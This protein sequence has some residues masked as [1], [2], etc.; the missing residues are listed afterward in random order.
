MQPRKVPFDGP[1]LLFHDCNLH[2]LY[3]SSSNRPH[4]VPS[5][6][7]TRSLIDFAK[8]IINESSDFIIML[9]EFMNFQ[10]NST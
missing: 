5:S 9:I 1:L 3:E 2:P 10:Y 8:S 7:I 6:I 4:F